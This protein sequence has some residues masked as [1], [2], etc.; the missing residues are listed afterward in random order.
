MPPQ[1]LQG[2]TVLVTGGGGG[3]GKAIAKAYLD[4]GANVAIC[5]INDERLGSARAEL[6]QTGRFLAAR[7]DITDEAA[8]QHLV[9]EIL[10]KFGR[11][12]VLVNN[13]GVMDRFDPVAELDQEVWARLLNINLTG[14][15]LCAKAAVNAFLKQGDGGLIIQIGSNASYTGHKSGLAYTVTKHGVLALVKHTASFY[16]DQGIYSICLMLGAMPDTNIADSFS[17]TGINKQG[18]E[19]TVGSNVMQPHNMIK[20]DDVAKY[21]LFLT[22][23]SIARSSNGALLT[24]A[25]N[26]PRA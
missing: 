18:Y 6:N 12:D 23:R 20:V 1:Q 13:A 15:F 4:A 24:F 26:W 8:I 22:D 19:K 21:A 17:T 25:G 11:L 16:G 3:L 14:S 5:D 7:V 2:T 9:D 10:V